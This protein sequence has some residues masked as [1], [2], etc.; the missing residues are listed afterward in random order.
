MTGVTIVNFSHPLTDAQRA[1]IEADLGGEIARVIDV[2]THFDAHRPFPGQALDLI[3][4]TGLSAIEWQTQP[5]LVNPPSLAAIAAVVL[6][7]LHGL[8]GHFPAIVRVR[9]G[10][11]SPKSSTSTRCAP[12][13]RTRYALTARGRLRPVDR[14]PHRGQLMFAVA[15]GEFGRFGGNRQSSF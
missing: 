1:A 12:G 9:T 11:S 10:S 13:L 6:A 14:R 15:G 8:M 2:P 7:Q 3:A 5:I 4:A